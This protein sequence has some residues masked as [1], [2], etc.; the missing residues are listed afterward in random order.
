MVSEFSWRRKNGRDEL[1]MIGLDLHDIV[2]EAAYLIHKIYCVFERKSP[3]YAKSFKSM[4]IQLVADPEAITWDATQ[5][6][7]KTPDLEVFFTT[8]GDKNK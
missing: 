2:S 5:A 6:N 3:M 7:S 8:P 4:V 1:R